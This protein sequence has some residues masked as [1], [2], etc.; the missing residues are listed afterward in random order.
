MHH[1]AVYQPHDNIQKGDEQPRHR[2]ALDEFRRAIQRAVE[3]GFRLFGFAAALGFGMVD[4]TRRHVAVNG[5]LFARHPVQREACA[6]F[7][8]AA[9]ALGDDDEIHD[10]QHKEDHDPQK[11]RSAHDEIGKALDHA[12]S[13]IRAGMP[14]AYDKFGRGYVQ[15]QTQ[16]ERRQKHGREDRKNPAGAE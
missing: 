10:Q 3:I 1:G 6:H 12:A 7:G 14:F 11:H 5:K 16:H 2:V 15:R 8:H 9:C 13:R 4:G